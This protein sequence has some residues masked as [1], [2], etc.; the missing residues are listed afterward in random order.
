MMN[1]QVQSVEDEVA[2]VNV[3]AT[4]IEPSQPEEKVR[5]EEFK[6]SNDAVLSKVKELIRKGNIRSIALKNSSGRTLVEIPLTVGVVGG[7]VGAVFFPVV[8]ALTAVGVLAAQ[9]TIVVA[10]KE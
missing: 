6:I 4:V 3:G 9:L 5:I 10:R 1:E 8:A 2:T 7:L